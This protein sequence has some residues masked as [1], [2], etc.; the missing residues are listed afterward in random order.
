MITQDEQDR[1]DQQQLNVQEKPVYVPPILT[2]FGNM[3]EI[4]GGNRGVSESICGSGIG[5]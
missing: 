5:S 1:L 4:N 2:V 3:M